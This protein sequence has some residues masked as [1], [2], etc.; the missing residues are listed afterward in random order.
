MDTRGLANQ[1]C[2]AWQVG[3]FFARRNDCLR[4][5]DEGWEGGV[6]QSETVLEVMCRLGPRC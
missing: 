4:D 2:F 5:G 3:L 6:Y 1:G